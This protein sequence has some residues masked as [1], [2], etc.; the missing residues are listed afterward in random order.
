MHSTQ[1]EIPEK[2]LSLQAFFLKNIPKSL[3]S[4]PQMTTQDQ[5]SA[6]RSLD[7][8]TPIPPTPPTNQQQG[9]SNTNVNVQE[10]PLV[11]AT[12]FIT[13][14]MGGLMKVDALRFFMYE[15]IQA[16]EC[17]KKDYDQRND[18]NFLVG[19]SRAELAEIWEKMCS[20]LE[21]KAD[22]PIFKQNCHF[23]EYPGDLFPL[24]YSNQARFRNFKR[25]GKFDE[26]KDPTQGTQGN[27]VSEG[28]QNRINKE[29][30]N[31]ENMANS[32]ENLFNENNQTPGDQNCTQNRVRSSTGNGNDQN[33]D[34]AN[35]LFTFSSNNHQGDSAIFSNNNSNN[36]SLNRSNE[37]GNSSATRMS[38]NNRS[39]GR[40]NEQ[41]SSNNRRG[42][43]NSGS[44]A[45]RNQ[46]QRSIDRSRERTRN[47]YITTAPPH[48]YNG[49]SFDNR[50]IGIETD[51]DEDGC[52]NESRNRR[53]S[54][55]RTN[56]GNNSNIDNMSEEFWRRLKSV[57]NECND[58]ALQPIK[59]DIG[60]LKNGFNKLQTAQN[61]NTANIAANADN[62]RRIDIELKEMEGLKER[63]I[64]LELDNGNG[65]HI[66]STF[67]A[68]VANTLRAQERIRYKRA[69]LAEKE[70]GTIRLDLIKNIYFYFENDI[71][72]INVEEIFRDLKV[73]IAIIHK[74]PR[75]NNTA[76][77]CVAVIKSN[78]S[79]RAKIVDNLIERR[80]EFAGKFGVRRIAPFEFDFDRIFEKWVDGKIIDGFN[81]T[82]GGFLVILVDEANQIK[83]YPF[84]PKALAELA[85]RFITRE[86][87]TKLADHDNFIIYKN[88]IHQLPNEIAEINRVNRANAKSRYDAIRERNNSQSRP[89]G[90]ITLNPSRNNS[91]HGRYFNG[92]YNMPQT[93]N[94]NRERNRDNGNFIGNGHQNNADRNANSNFNFFS[95]SS[96]SNRNYN[97][98]IR[99]PNSYGSHNIPNF[100]S[101]SSIPNRGPINRNTNIPNIP[102]DP[103]ISNNRNRDTSNFNNQD[104]FR[105]GLNRNGY[106]EDVPQSS[107][108]RRNSGNLDTID[109]EFDEEEGMF[110]SNSDRFLGNARRQSTS[111]NGYWPPKPASSS[112]NSSNRNMTS[113]LRNNYGNGNFNGFGQDDYG[114]RNGG[115]RF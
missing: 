29:I 106:G 96:S 14:S 7:S 103:S 72:I 65:A 98:N 32:F 112:K 80:H 78:I 88:A 64:A 114:S 2:L 42:R 68:S 111:N 105:N 37:Q 77:T 25:T 36:T 30:Q 3:K 52:G 108:S 53:E 56:N 44:R 104:N 83:F 16:N 74:W 21:F 22:N 102:T 92:D 55:N 70:K 4:L 1:Q 87:M 73:H 31:S 28:L 57:N 75:K 39:R 15:V 40:A 19:S 59:V 11:Q 35:S 100:P 17:F 27:T 54:G 99:A 10:E 38:N 23:I 5:L 50:P 101:G 20:H 97:S 81:Y 89:I 43:N 63:V 95:G 13:K 71:L 115:F 93:N 86:W 48:G 18:P 41:G 12:Q 33:G 66:L 110:D 24:S 62:I 107:Q 51:S 46:S 45:A 26:N 6:D 94:Y 109:E 69:I 58:E 82:K 79:N 84:S 47:R 8:S 85:V 49:A 9:S 61:L 113:N 34:N 91:S 76:A 60:D 67:E 90:P